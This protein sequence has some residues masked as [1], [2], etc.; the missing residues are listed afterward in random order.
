MSEGVRG[1]RPRLTHT[2][3]HTVS[4]NTC[5]LLAREESKAFLVLPPFLIKQLARAFTFIA[6]LIKKVSLCVFEEHLIASKLNISQT[7]FILGAKIVSKL[8]HNKLLKSYFFFFIVWVLH[9]ILNLVMRLGRDWGEMAETGSSPGW[10]LELR[11]FVRTW[12]CTALPGSCCLRYDGS[13]ADSCPPSSHGHLL[14]VLLSL[15][16]MFRWL[17]HS[18]ISI[19]PTVLLPGFLCAFQPHSLPSLCFLILSTSH[20]WIISLSFKET[21]GL[22]S[23]REM[24]L[25]LLSNPLSRGCA[26]SQWVTF[27]SAASIDQKPG[28]LTLW[29]VM[30][31][32]PEAAC[33][34]F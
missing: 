32:F 16:F 10:R 29:G 33:F 17:L 18:M 24:F 8:F 21:S 12:D 26:E 14:M 9:W 3:T 25:T 15:S 22:G 34:S 13:P 30:Q 1:W 4:H 19:Q 28:Q 20:G 5:P 31:A 11:L 2:D 6:S 23:K 7:P 27:S